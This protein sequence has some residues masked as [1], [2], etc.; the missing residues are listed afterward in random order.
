M[1]PSDIELVL[2]LPTLSQRRL[3]QPDSRSTVGCLT[4]LMVE[5]QRHVVIAAPFMQRGHGLSSGPLA[6]AL[7]AALERGLNVD[8]LGTREGL[9]TL[10][11]D[12]L[13]RRSSG[14]LQLW[15]PSQHV[16]DPRDLGSHAKFCIADGQAAYVG[17]ANFT[18]PGLGDQ[19]EMGVLVKGP[20]A[21]QIQA[22]WDLACKTGFFVCV[23][24]YHG[25]RSI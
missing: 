8:V 7:A 6:F 20:V 16:A 15:E 13:C 3:Y 12:T 2:T 25:R 14:R 24:S 5:A 17:S 19:L 18:G 1:T 4:Q 22:F 9:S 10:L 23:D 11:I 21:T